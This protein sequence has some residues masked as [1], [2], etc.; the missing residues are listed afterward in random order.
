M[1]T[2]SNLVLVLMSVA[3][4]KGVAAPSE[5]QK[6]LNK[7][8]A[9]ESLREME[10]SHVQAA[11]SAE[12]ARHIDLGE[13]TLIVIEE[14]LPAALQQYDETLRGEKGLL[15]NEAGR[16]L[17]QNPDVVET[18]LRFVLEERFQAN[19][20]GPNSDQID[21]SRLDFGPRERVQRVEL[22]RQSLKSLT[23]FRGGSGT[24][25]DPKTSQPALT[26]S[27]NASWAARALEQLE[28]RNTLIEGYQAA[29]PEGVN[30]T[31]L[32]TLEEEILATLGRR[33]ATQEALLNDVEKKAADSK[34]AKIA[35]VTKSIREQQLEAYI[36][37]M[38]SLAAE[39]ARLAAAKA[40][41][42][43][44]EVELRGKEQL[45][46]NKAEYD[47][48]ID[49]MNQE[50]ADLDKKLA[51]LA[52]ELDNK[53]AEIK[54][55][56][57]KVVVA[58]TM[59]VLPQDA[60]IIVRILSTPGFYKPTSIQN[61]PVTGTM[62]MD[63]SSRYPGLNP[64]PHSLNALAGCGALD[65]TSKGIMTM[66]YILAGSPDAERPRFQEFYPIRF[67][68]PSN[69]EALVPRDIDA[70]L[71][72]SESA[73]SATK[74]IQEIQKLIREYG[75]ELVAAGLLAP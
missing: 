26:I 54:T 48:R 61:S 4:L 59:R 64:Q 16:F 57:D 1:K 44:Q 53:Q 9:A 10:R 40:E 14:A 75:D 25:F 60:K 34:A 68:Y 5:A 43:R 55:L 58:K 52:V 3:V 23:E 42:E 66:Y 30:V 2:A 51:A 37:D 12:V 21:N 27:A 41:R 31:G 69:T 29:V 67:G 19:S 73:R 18:L 20:S 63:F 28:N 45:E 71:T 56:K 33:I 50:R 46:A 72:A 6:Q 24:N 65:E 13:K 47:R 22:V 36:G 39:D 49:K 7:K 62:A 74:K 17:S 32:P 35:E 11:G 8:R 70:A 38:K 15:K